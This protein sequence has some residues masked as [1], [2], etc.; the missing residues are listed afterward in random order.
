M[1]GPRHGHQFELAKRQAGQQVAIAG[2]VHQHGVSGLQQRAGRHVQ[3]TAGALSQRDVV[4]ASLD[5]PFGQ[6]VG[7]MLAQG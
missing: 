5:A 4:G 6:A 1:F 2:I 7:Q 3:R